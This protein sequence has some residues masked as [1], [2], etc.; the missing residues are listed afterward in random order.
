[1]ILVQ[2]MRHV[3][4]SFKIREDFIRI[5]KYNCWLCASYEI[6]VVHLVSMAA[7]GG[8]QGGTVAPPYGFRFL[9]YW[10]FFLHCHLRSVMAMIVPV[11]HYEMCVEIFL[12]SEKKCVGVPPPPPLSDFFRACANVMARAAVVRHFYNFVP[13]KQTPWRRPWFR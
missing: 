12:K 1:M 11:S 7:P 10:F 3:K 8:W 13:P 6:N 5:N 9:F 2:S 4:I